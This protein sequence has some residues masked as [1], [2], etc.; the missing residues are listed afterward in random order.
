MEDIDINIG[1]RFR[2][3]RKELGYSQKEIAERIGVDRPT[4]NKVELN[5][6]LPSAHT[7]YRLMELDVSLDWL[8]YGVGNMFIISDDHFLNH[9]NSEQIEFLEIFNSLNPDVREQILSGFLSILK[10]QP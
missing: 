6:R 1:K 2:E 3:L 5:K 9:L 10:A 7:L 4:I 8:L